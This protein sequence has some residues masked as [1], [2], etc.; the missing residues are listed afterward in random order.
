MF[1]ND[2]LYVIFIEIKAKTNA[3]GNRPI[4]NGK[5]EVTTEAQRNGATTKSAA[6]FRRWAQRSRAATKNP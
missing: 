2:Y 4:G 3:T 6:D 5:T 1:V